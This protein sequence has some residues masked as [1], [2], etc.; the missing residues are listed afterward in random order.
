MAATGAFPTLLNRTLYRTNVIYRSPSTAP[1]AST[2]RPP[3]YRI[4]AT[5]PTTTG[6]G[7]TPPTAVYPVNVDPS[8]TGGAQPVSTFGGTTTSGGT[9]TGF[10][11][12]TGGGTEPTAEGTTLTTPGTTT[13]AGAGGSTGGGSDTS[14]LLDL[15][16][17]AFAPHDI[18][19]PYGPQSVSDVSAPSSGTNPMAILVLAIM[20]IIGVVWWTNRKKKAA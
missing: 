19:Q 20:A 1:V 14:H 15:I 2:D 16:A 13:G 11:P 5:S 7:F 6:G 3:A 17:G 9:A 18:S 4:P 10:V 8:G 12:S